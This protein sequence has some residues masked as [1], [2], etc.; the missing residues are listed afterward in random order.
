MGDFYPGGL[1]VQL[2]WPIH[3]LA[4][5][6]KMEIKIFG[7]GCA[8]CEELAATVAAL[9]EA[10]GGDISVRKVSDLKEML[11]AGVMSTPALAID[12]KV[13][14]AG[15]IPGKEEIAAWIGA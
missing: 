14:S 10:N 6:K 1:A 4:W 3:R 11:A 8:K 5:E 12:G 13:M 7:I 2:A 9:A 15:R